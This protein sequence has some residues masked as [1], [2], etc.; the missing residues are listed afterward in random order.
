[1]IMKFAKI[2]MI[3]CLSASV[4][5]CNLRPLYAGGSQGAVAT[6][7]GNIEVEPIAGKAGWL[8]GNALRDHLK[9][10]EGQETKYRL[11]VELDDKVAGFG[12][13]SD[14]RITRERRTLRARYQLVRLA[15]TKVVLDATAGSDI[16]IDVVSSEYATLAAENTALENLAD[17]VANQII[18]RLSQFAHKQVGTEPQP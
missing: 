17:R 9:P 15:D 6:S 7:L 13:R 5:G 8:T 16:G 1:M 3:L 18:I 4:A 14:D 11:I 12:V 2:A 10:L